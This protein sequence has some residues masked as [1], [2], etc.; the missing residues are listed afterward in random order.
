MNTRVI[1]KRA[2]ST[3][4]QSPMT[5]GHL[6]TSYVSIHNGHIEHVMYGAQYM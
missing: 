6:E 3:L 1:G 4:K 5:D 2:L